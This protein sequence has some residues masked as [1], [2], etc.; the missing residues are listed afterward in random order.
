MI[1]SFTWL[2]ARPGSRT[3][4]AL[5]AGPLAVASDLTLTA[6]ILCG[7]LGALALCPIAFNV[8]ASGGGAI[9]IRRGAQIVV[10][11]AR[12][13]RGAPNL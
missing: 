2:T 11:G 12:P 13:A 9:W 1:E 3:A 4:S 10:G 8:R 5:V 7:F 6:L